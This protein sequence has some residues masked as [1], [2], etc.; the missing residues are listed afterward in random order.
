MNPSEQDKAIL[1]Q[2]YLEAIYQI[3]EPRMAM[4]PG[5]ANEVLV[6][7]LEYHRIDNWAVITADNPQSELLPDDENL[8]RYQSLR[9]EVEAMT[10]IALPGFGLDRHGQWPPER[11]LLILGL[12][13]EEAAALGRKYGQLAI[14]W[15]GPEGAGEVLWCQ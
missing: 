11:N 13:G 15:G 2:A 4:I 12:S 7:L 5:V 9:E 14:V 1:E 6:D 3:D 10:R 8:K